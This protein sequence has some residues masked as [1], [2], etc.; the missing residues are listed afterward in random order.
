MNEVPEPFDKRILWKWVRCLLRMLSPFS[1]ESKRKYLREKKLL[2]MLTGGPLHQVDREV[3]GWFWRF[4]PILQ[5]TKGLHRVS[6]QIQSTVG[7]FL[8]KKRVWIFHDFPPPKKKL[9]KRIGSSCMHPPKKTTVRSY[10]TTRRLK[11]LKREVMK[12][13]QITV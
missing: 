5:D 8:I 9:C 11:S 2:W 13:P 6:F 3:S 12:I 10:V 1:S 4:A 7:P